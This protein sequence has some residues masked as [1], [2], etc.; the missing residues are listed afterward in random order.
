MRYWWVVL[1]ASGLVVW[2]CFELWKGL[3]NGRMASVALGGIEGS[4][5]RRP[6]LFWLIA[7]SNLTIV[8]F[9]VGVMVLALG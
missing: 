6:L 2:C 1:L 8:V 3:R 4:R 9:C 7:A 5:R